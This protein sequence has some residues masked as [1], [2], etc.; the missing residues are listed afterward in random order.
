MAVAEE[1]NF[2]QN[3]VRDMLDVNQP[4]DD[5]YWVLPVSDMNRLVERY[6]VYYKLEPPKL[7]VIT[8]LMANN[9][10]WK[11]VRALKIYDKKLIDTRTG[12]NAFRKSTVRCWNHCRA[13]NTSGVLDAKHEN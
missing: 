5:I 7:K 2:V 10:I 11:V 12:K 4:G 6:C 3:F 9:G 1:K 13:K 8:E